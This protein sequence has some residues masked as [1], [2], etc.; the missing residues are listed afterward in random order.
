MTQL[1][2]RTEILNQG[3]RYRNRIIGLLLGL[4]LIHGLAYWRI[5]D[6]LMVY[7]PPDLTRPQTVAV[8]EIPSS[9]VYAFAKIVMESLNYCPE[10][11]AEDYGNNLEE[12]RH[13]LTPSCFQE[14]SMHREGHASLYRHRSRKL[15]PLG[16]ELFDPA[17]VTRLDRNAWAVTVEYLL[18]EH[19]VGVETRRNRYRYPLRI[20]HLGLPVHLNAYQLAFDCYTGPGPHPVETS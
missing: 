10:D 8:S 20:V 4:L 16:E 2:N 12:L 14:L 1:V 18:E 3:I 9:Y 19:V 5:P 17:K 13:Y 7:V 11:C 6:T 15:L